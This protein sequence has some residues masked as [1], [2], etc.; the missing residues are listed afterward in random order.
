MKDTPG[1][2]FLVARAVFTAYCLL[3]SVYCLL[4]YLPFT[5]QQVIEFKVV[6]WTG[7]F[8]RL[9]PWLF[10][11]ALGC[12]A[13]T[14]A[15]DYRAGARAPVVAFAAAG[16]AAG[17]VLAVSPLLAGIRNEGRSLA[18][19]AVWLLPLWWMALIDL[20]H[21]GR[22]LSWRGVRP[23]EDL[24]LFLALVLAGIGAALTYAV[25]A[26]FRPGFPAGAE[27]GNAWPGAPGV[28]LWSL[29]LHLLAFLAVFAALAFLRGVA[30]S[31]GRPALAEF[32][33]VMAA[34]AALLTGV[35]RGVVFAAVSLLGTPGLLMAVAYAVSL[36]VVAAGASVRLWPAATPVESGIELALRPFGAPSAARPIVKGALLAAWAP[37]AYALAMSTAVMDWNYLGQTVA[38]LTMWFALVAWIYAAL[39]HPGPGFGRA[40]AGLLAVP[41]ILLGGFRA[42]GAS[43]GSL[44]GLGLGPENRLAQLDRY[45]GYDVSFRLL[46]NLVRREPGTPGPSVD[47][48]AFYTLLQRHTNISRAI[49]IDVPRLDIVPRIT[50]PGGRLPHVFVIVIDS[51]RQDYLSPYNPAVS[52]TPATAHFAAEPGTTVFRRAFTRYG[53]TGLSEPAI[54]TGS[55][56]PHQ[57][58]PSPFGQANTLQTLV[59]ALGYEAHVSIDT[60]LL[61][62]LA[63]WPEVIEL[64]KGIA[65]RDYDLR[66][67]LEELARQLKARSPSNT[68]PVFAFTQPQNIHVSAIAREGASVP[69]GESYPGFNAPYAARVRRLDAAFGAF[70][71]DLRALGLYDDSIVIL[72]SDHGD[73]LGEEGRFGHAYTIYPEILR[74][75]LVVHLPDTLRGL[76]ADAGAVAMSTD[77]TPTLYYLL[78]QRPTINHPLFGRPLFTAHPDE[79]AAYERADVVVASSYGPVY[80]LLAADASSLYIADATSYRD[81]EYDLT[82]G[83]AGTPRPVTA[84]SRAAGASRIRQAIGQIADTFRVPIDR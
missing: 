48:G 80:G 78:G 32:A 82:T 14:L 77:I 29:M 47:M 35:V 13:W 79:R 33:L 65:N 38:A 40:L 68:A 58:Y 63:P 81:Y 67:T 3:T 83:M 10:W 41:V 25:C 28:V 73:S 70:L 9:H 50:P 46:H 6:G 57:Q 4:A 45:A 44:A 31:F 8:A 75:P 55:M 74:I 72:T 24:R 42:L 34:G 39:P 52:F 43:P 54:W 37:V 23:G 17:C 71:D 59:R 76:S 49:T 27:G 30:S 62:V 60:P 56:L 1:I 51:L 53:A 19:A 22:R 84:A 36:A 64:D 61:A 26:Y 2:G 20:M 16:V 66:R 18:W 12:A 7:P 69:P 11:I 21:A 15:K 5:Y